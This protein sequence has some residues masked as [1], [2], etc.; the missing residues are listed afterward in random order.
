MVL[1]IGTKAVSNA[2]QLFE[3]PRLV[4]AKFNH[5]SMAILPVYVTYKDN[6]NKET[7]GIVQED[8]ME[9]Y[10]MQRSFYGYFITRKPKNVNWTVEIQQYEE[11]NRRLTEAGI[12]YAD[13]LQT[14][15]DELSKILQ[16]DAIYI[17]E[18]K[19]LKTISD[20]AAVALDIFVGY[21]GYT[22]NID[23]E[24]SI[25]EGSSGELMWKYDRQLPTSYWG[26]SDYL[27]DNIMKLNIKKFPYK[28]KKKK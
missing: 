25:Y 15:K 8:E 12:V 16:V 1:L 2:Q 23:V 20:A 21:G 19:K 22:G 9:G 27:V 26:R 7:K 17:C 6:S 24:T 13:L 28:E 11:T 10:N 4:S 18:V 5:K 3:S 14:P